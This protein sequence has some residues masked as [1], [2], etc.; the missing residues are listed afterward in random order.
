LVD[1]C[2]CGWEM[3]VERFPKKKKKKLML[4]VNELDIGAN[5]VILLVPMLAVILET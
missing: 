1:G 5:A 2:V 3:L 4:C